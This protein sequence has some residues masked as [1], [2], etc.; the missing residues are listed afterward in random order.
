M[1]IFQQGQVNP[2]ALTVP[3][4]YVQ[5]IPPPPLNL[6]GVPSNKLGIVGTAAWGPVNSPV[7]AGGYAQGA[8]TF[9]PL[10]ARKYDMMTQ[11]ATAAAQGANNFRLVRVTDGSDTA[12]TGTLACANAALATALANAVNNGVSVQRGASNLVVASASGTTLTLTGK[13][14]GSLGNSIVANL[15]PGSAAN[16]SSLTISLPGLSP[17]S[18]T[19]V[20]V[21]SSSAASVNLGGG[22]DGVATMTG[23]L[24]LGQDALTRKGMYA[25][26]ST[27]VSVALLADCD[28]ST[29]W[30]TQVGYGLSEGTEM[31][32]TGPSGDTIANA[33]AVKAGAG[34]D[35]YA[36]KLMLGD[37]I[38][39]QD[40]INNVIRLVSPQ[41]FA[42]G[43]LAALNPNL[44]VLNSSLNAIAGTQKTYASQLYTQAELAQ[45]AQAGIDVIT[46]PS[47]GGSYFS[48]VLGQNTSSDPLRN[49][50]SY[51]RMTNY[52]A[53]TLNS[54]GGEFVGQNETKDEQ[55]DAQTRLSSF[56]AALWT[57]Q[58]IGNP[59]GTIPYSVEIDSG[60]NSVAQEALGYQIATVMVQ[61]LSTVKFFLVNL[62]GGTSVII[63][64]SNSPFSGTTAG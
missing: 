48:C 34:I 19:N 64:Q 5:I 28:D 13:Y 41:G 6:N 44:S 53:T 14:T 59:N 16:T 30:S 25:L 61:Y 8:A 54:A 18:F 40:T 37:W 29:T 23:A 21:A 27:G 26:R 36:A 2:T 52:L 15:G 35:S 63:S 43:R 51:T 58:M 4:T 60:N 57:N 39:W 47:P 56:L 50:D 62:T 46:N 38:Y 42:A 22:T 17:E 49:D 20:G 1:P 9:G 32:L 33:V 3:G 11:V 31:V 7:V 24:L 12:A 10:Q 55:E 45:L